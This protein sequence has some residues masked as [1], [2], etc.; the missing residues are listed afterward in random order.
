MLYQLSY[1]R[2]A[3]PLIYARAGSG[4]ESY[5]IPHSIVPPDPHTAHQW[6]G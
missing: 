2:D 5:T 6:W 3:L 4:P 1:T